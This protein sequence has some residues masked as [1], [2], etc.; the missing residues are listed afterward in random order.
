MTLLILY[1]FDIKILNSTV[2]I[3]PGYEMVAGYAIHKF[4]W[5]TTQTNCVCLFFQLVE[6][7]F[8]QK[9]LFKRLS[10][11]TLQKDEIYEEI[12]KPW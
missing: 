2:E 10:K 5:S 12:S 9:G 7:K 1:P 6:N 8:S 3:V 11:L 4:L